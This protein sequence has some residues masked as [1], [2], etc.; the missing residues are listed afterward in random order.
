MEATIERHV[1]DTRNV[2][3]VSRN[4]FCVSATN[5]VTRVNGSEVA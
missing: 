5:F 4:I 1:A 3:D 2:S